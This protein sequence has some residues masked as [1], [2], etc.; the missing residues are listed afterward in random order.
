MGLGNAWAENLRRKSLC[1]GTEQIDPFGNETSVLIH[2]SCLSGINKNRIKVG[3]FCL[4]HTLSKKVLSLEHNREGSIIC[5]STPTRHVWVM[6]STLHVVFVLYIINIGYLCQGLSC[7]LSACSAVTWV[8][9]SKLSMS[10]QE[11]DTAVKPVIYFNGPDVREKFRHGRWSCLLIL[12]LR[13]ETNGIAMLIHL[14]KLPHKLA[15]AI[16]KSVINKHQ[17]LTDVHWMALQMRCTQ[18][19]SILVQQIATLGQEQYLTWCKSWPEKLPRDTQ[20]NHDLS[21][22]LP[23]YCKLQHWYSLNP[24]RVLDLPLPLKESS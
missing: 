1:Q 17:P 13:I 20:D 18:G 23:T 22:M 9:S 14:A 21:G 16:S 5:W 15:Q 19:H 7:Q 8:L 2:K 6:F 3:T 24:R 10:L 12:P 4:Y 11:M